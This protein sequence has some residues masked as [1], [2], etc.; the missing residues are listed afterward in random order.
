MAIKFFYSI[1]NF[2]KILTLSLKVKTFIIDNLKRTWVQGFG[3]DI[4]VKTSK[5]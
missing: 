1:H 3:F 4:L 5:E 2:H